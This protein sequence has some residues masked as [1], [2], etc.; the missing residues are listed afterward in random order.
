MNH[1]RTTSGSQLRY[2]RPLHLYVLNTENGDYKKQHV[3]PVRYLP[4]REQVFCT[5]V[6][7]G[8][9]SNDPPIIYDNIG[10][11]LTSSGRQ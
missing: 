4:N 6:Q 8:N 10:H 5:R 9:Y 11:S 3:H 1:H 2:E 7:I